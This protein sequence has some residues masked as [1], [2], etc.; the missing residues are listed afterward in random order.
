MELFYDFCQ[1]DPFT[2]KAQDYMYPFVNLNN[3][4]QKEMHK[5]V[6]G[7]WIENHKPEDVMKQEIMDKLHKAAAKEIKETVEKQPAMAL[8]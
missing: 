8:A 7:S 3:V 1:K 2:G 5:F 6:I 4:D